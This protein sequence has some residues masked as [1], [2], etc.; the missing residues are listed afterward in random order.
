MI[1]IVL[2]LVVRLISK[3]NNII[4]RLPVHVSCLSSYII[5]TF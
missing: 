1:I 4:H 2:V 5:L 3:V